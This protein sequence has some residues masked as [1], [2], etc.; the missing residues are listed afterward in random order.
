MFDDDPVVGPQGLRGGPVPP[1]GR[2]RDLG[3]GVEVLV[4][5]GKDL[6]VE[7]LKLADSV[8]HLAQRLRAAMTCTMGDHFKAQK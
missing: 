6:V 7:H 4:E 2:G 5:L 1:G 8:G 3:G